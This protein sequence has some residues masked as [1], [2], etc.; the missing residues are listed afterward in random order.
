MKMKCKNGDLVVFDYEA[1][2]EN[3]NFEG[4]E[5]KNTQIVLGKDLFIKGFDKQ[6]LG[7]KKNKKKKLKLFYLKI[8][9]KKNLQIKKQIL[10][11]KF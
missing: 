1:T 11:V 2:I 6:L 5:G 8:I 9:Q 3:K 7:V 10:N 4:G